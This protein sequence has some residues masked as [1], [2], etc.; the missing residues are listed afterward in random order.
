MNHV[1]Y[2]RHP[3]LVG[4]APYAAPACSC[5]WTGSL[6]TTD[7]RALG[8]ISAHIFRAMKERSVI[9]DARPPLERSHLPQAA[10]EQ[11][12]SDF[13]S[14]TYVDPYVPLSDADIV[15]LAERVRRVIPSQERASMARVLQVLSEVRELRAALADIATNCHDRACD[16]VVDGVL[17]M[18]RAC[19]CCEAYA[20]EVLADAAGAVA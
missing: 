13:L 2:L 14:D 4:Q 17:A 16:R 9:D 7:D 15:A 19:R 20:A 11:K 12:L 5:G 1:G 3:V 18:D 10:I 6:W 8:E